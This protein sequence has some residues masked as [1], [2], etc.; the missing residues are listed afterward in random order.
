MDVLIHISQQLSNSTIASYTPAEF[1]VSPSI[2]A[3]N[4]LFFLSLA[5]VLI[6]AFLAMLVKSWLQEFDRGWRKYTVAKL[7]AQERERRLQGLEHWKLAELVVLLP[8]LIQISLLLFC[9]GLLVL[10]FPI[11][12]TSAIFASVALLAGLAFY[13]FTT[14]VSILDAY[15]P[16]SSPISRGLTTLIKGLRTTWMTLTRNVQDIISSVSLHIFRLLSPREHEENPKP[17]TQ[18]LPGRGRVARS[19]SPLAN[20]ASKNRGVVPQSHSKFDY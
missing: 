3:V 4:V 2:A 6:D 19:P 17:S 7:R 15:A 10:L 16:F 5:L 9:V 1:T 8:I 13:V 11:H 14:Y 12:L 20:K 18:S